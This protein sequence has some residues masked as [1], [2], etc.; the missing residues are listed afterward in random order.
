VYIYLQ[1]VVGALLAAWRLG[2][3]PSAGTYVGGLMIACGIWLVSR[4]TGRR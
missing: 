1:P 2:E 4:A 3:R